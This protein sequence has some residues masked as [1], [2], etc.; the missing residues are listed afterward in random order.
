MLI[1]ILLPGHCVSKLHIMTAFRKMTAELRLAINSEFSLLDINEST[2]YS[3]HI[4]KLGVCQV[5][6]KLDAL[7]KVS[8]ITKS[9]HSNIQNSLETQKF[10]PIT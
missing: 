10:K 8:I 5:T 9:Q 6:L 3:Q 1:L 7:I 2:R 4:N